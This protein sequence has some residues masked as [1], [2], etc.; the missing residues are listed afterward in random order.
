MITTKKLFEQA[1]NIK[2]PHTGLLEGFKA[3]TDVVVVLVLEK[4]EGEMEKAGAA[5]THELKA[6][7]LIKLD[8]FSSYKLRAEI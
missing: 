7:S 3:D 4:Q 1:K 8:F 6:T 5:R 2:C